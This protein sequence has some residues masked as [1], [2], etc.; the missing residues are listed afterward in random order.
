MD[1]CRPEFK[2]LNLFRI[3][4]GTE[5]DPERAFLAWFC[6]MLRQPAKVELHLPFVFRFERFPFQ[7]HVGTTGIATNVDPVISRR[8]PPP[9]QSGLPDL[10]DTQMLEF[11]LLDDCP[12][13]R[14]RSPSGR[15][16]RE[17]PAEEFLVDAPATITVSRGCIGKSG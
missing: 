3:L 4:A 7:F 10:G 14:E 5:N 8:L 16:T 9:P 17:R 6:F 11:Q 2:Q 1:A 13:L 12:T 15:P